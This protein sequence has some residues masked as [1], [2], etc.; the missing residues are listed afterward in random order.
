MLGIIR[1]FARKMEYGS[2]ASVPQTQA[3]SEKELRMSVFKAMCFVALLKL[4]SG[5]AML[6]F[7]PIAA[8]VASSP[9]RKVAAIFSTLLLCTTTTIMGG[10]VFVHSATYAIA[11]KAIF[12]VFSVILTMKAAGRRW[13]PAM[14]PVS[15]LMLY[16]AFQAAAS[17]FG[18]A[19]VISELKILLMVMFVMA[20]ANACTLGASGGVDAGKIR[21]IMLTVCCVM[22][23]GSILVY[24]F[25]SIS[26]AMTIAGLSEWSD[27][28]ESEL[29][30]IALAMEQSLY[31]GIAGHS[32]TL[33]PMC[34]VLNAFLFADYVFNVRKVS[35][36]YMVLML[37]SAG[38]IYM[39]GS[40]TAMAAYAFS[41]LVCAHFANGARRVPNRKKQWLASVVLSIGILGT[42]A[43][44]VVPSV[45]ERAVGFLM[46]RGE[47]GELDMAAV[48]SSRQGLI[49]RSMFFFR[50]S[51][52]IGNGFQVMWTMKGRK[53]NGIKSVLSAPIE[54]GFLPSMM[55]EEGGLVGGAIFLAFLLS[56]M[57][58][59]KKY[60]Y[61]CFLTC[62]LTFVIT[63]MGEATFFSMS[64]MGGF[65]WSVCFAAFL[66]DADRAMRESAPAL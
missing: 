12:L 62:F 51:P 1:V 13:P 14:K 24:P 20:G 11:T 56:M 44:A 41:I 15:V 48:L 65:G 26:R 59:C 3:Y 50:Q 16:L 47:T 45:R 6:A 58:A 4:T 53:I 36:L 43:V 46:K 42:M 54:K 7:V 5:I 21:T 8:S 17:M 27:Q 30:E 37:C 61:Y 66:L 28:S 55:L 18:W 25:P 64:G 19:P 49:D 39:T 38:L 31:N 52:L 22:M 63:N 60:R 57:A 10:A 33:G 34:A 35:R 23:I 40:R 32:Q 29:I 9:R 2:M